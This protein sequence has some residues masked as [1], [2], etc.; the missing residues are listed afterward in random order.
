MQTA[1]PASEEKD[2]PPRMLLIR[3]YLNQIFDLPF[4][5]IKVKEPS[6]LYYLPVTEDLLDSYLSQGY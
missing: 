4:C 1:S 2:P 6:L 3:L 5:H